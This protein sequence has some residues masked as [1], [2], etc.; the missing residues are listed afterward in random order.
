MHLSVV[1]PV[2]NAEKIIPELVKQVHAAVLP[3]QIDYEI[4]LVEDCGSDN[5]WQVI[6]QICEHDKKIVGIKLS[7]NF[8]QHY[9]ITA[10]LNLAQGDYVIVMDCDL[11]DNPTY[12][13]QLLSLIKQGYEIVY[14]RK[15]YRKH[16]WFKN[17]TAGIFNRVF[18]YLVDNKNYKS[19][20]NVGSYSILSRKVVNNFNQFNDYHRHY[21]M[22][23]RWMGF[24]HSY[25]E[26]EHLDRFEGKSSYGFKKLV[27]HA[28][29]GIVSQSD[30]ILR[31][32]VYFG[33]LISVISFLSIL[34]IVMYALFFG[35]A[36][37]W[38][39][40]F[41][42][43]LFSLGIILT[44]LGIVGIYVGKTFEQSKNRPK[45][46]IEQKIN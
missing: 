31:L 1:S 7:R 13:P 35:F 36:S 16:S 23:L 10:G 2:Y 42:M 22:V 26:I 21:L 17:I 30:K 3:L 40:I 18:N 14:T 24:S 6:Q 39:S 43:M 25:I 11:Q 34:G 33:L 19:F 12:I 5:S 32:F 29:D 4:V 8:G 45:Y 46:I 37:G 20:N 9:A 28:I 38:A 44:S 27:N 15:L 41:V